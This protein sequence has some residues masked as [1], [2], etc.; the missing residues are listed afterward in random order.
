MLYW[1]E[2]NGYQLPVQ[3]QVQLLRDREANLLDQNLNELE[4]ELSQGRL[5]MIYS[6]LQKEIKYNKEGL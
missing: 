5:I 6:L 3:I 2:M 1:N 4:F